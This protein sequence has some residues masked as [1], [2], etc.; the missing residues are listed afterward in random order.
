MNISFEGEKGKDLTERVISNLKEEGVKEHNSIALAQNDTEDDGGDI[1][2]VECETIAQVVC[3]ELPTEVSEIKLKLNQHIVETKAE[4]QKIKENFA[5][6]LD[7]LKELSLN[8]GTKVTEYCLTSLEHENATL[9]HENTQLRRENDSLKERDATHNTWHTPGHRARTNVHNISANYACQNKTARSAA[10]MNAQEPDIIT[11]NRF[12]LLS[13]EHD[14]DKESESNDEIDPSSKNNKSVKLVFIAGD[15]ILQHVHGWDLSNDKQRV[16]VKSFSGSKADDMQDYIKPL[17]RKKPD[18]II[19]HVGTN[20]IKDNAKT[21]EVVAA[22][23]LNLG[24]QIKDSLPYHALTKFHSTASDSTNEWF[25]NMDRG[26][27]N[28]AVFLD[29]QKAFDTINHDILLTKLD[30]YGLQKPSLNLLVSYLANRTQMC[31]VNGALSGT[32]LV[33]CGIPQGSTLGPLLFLI[34]INDLPN[35]LEYSSTRMFADD[36]ILTVSG[37]SM[38]DVEVAINHDLT[39][40]KQWLSA[41]RLSLNL[42]KTEYLLIGSR[43]N[44]NNL[45]AAPNVFV[46]DTPIKKLGMSNISGNITTVPPTGLE[47]PVKANPYALFQGIIITVLAFLRKRTSFKKDVWGGRPGLVVPIDFLGIDNDR[48][49]IMCV[50]GAATGSITNLIIVRDVGQN[51]WGAA[52][53]SIG[54]ALEV[55]FLY[56]P[57]FGCLASYHRIIGALMGLPYVVVY[58]SISMTADLQK[59]NGITTWAQYVFEILPK[60]PTIL[61][62]LFIMGKFI[63]VLYKEIKEYG[64]FGMQLFSPHN[65][66]E[67][68]HEHVKL[69]R[70]WLHDHVNDLIK[71]KKLI[72]SLYSG[73]YEVVTVNQTDQGPWA[74]WV[75]PDSGQAVLPTTHDNEE[76]Y[77]LGM[78]VTFA[79]TRPLEQDDQKLPP[80]PILFLLTTDG[81]LCPFYIVYKN[82]KLATRI[83]HPPQP[84]AVDGERLASSSGV[85]KPAG[86][87]ATQAAPVTM[88]PTKAITPSVTQATNPPAT[89]STSFTAS[90]PPVLPDNTKAPQFGFSPLTGAQ[91]NTTPLT[92]GPSKATQATK[93][94]TT[95]T[96]AVTSKPSVLPDNTRAPQFG[97]TP[98]T[99]TPPSTTLP[100]FG[101]TKIFGSNLAGMPTNPGNVSFSPV[102]LPPSA[103]PGQTGLFQ[104]RPPQ[105]PPLTQSGFGSTLSK[106]GP[107]SFVPPTASTPSSA[108]SSTSGLRTTKPTEPNVPP[109]TDPTHKSTIPSTT[110]APD[111]RGTT[112]VKTP[113]V[114]NAKPPPTMQPT[115]N[116][117]TPV[118]VKKDGV[119]PGS[120]EESKGKPL[121]KASPSKQEQLE[122]A[123]HRN[124]RN[125]ASL[126]KMR[127]IYSLHYTYGDL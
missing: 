74:K 46:G 54:T 5:E 40:V 109:K 117:G 49:A 116:L 71:S 45:L 108:Q 76:T 36:T 119:V 111:V 15:S 59:C 99:G 42:V 88:P 122:A 106:S 4:L 50:F 102:S 93:L 65:L 84:L 60:I 92:F 22:G 43:Y 41:N 63:L 57:Y 16:S 120:K 103:K 56:Y 55:A 121:A 75:L 78:A 81:V 90:K 64:I 107:L 87:L 32:K 70:P 2:T 82:S 80:A 53:L 6:Q 27:F 67:H 98:F 44:I 14:S 114:T 72:L 39:N 11:P 52:F 35:S 25:I 91:P 19:L 17:L 3:N 73:A 125:E 47:L 79:V 69:I 97:S 48:L 20:N 86:S 29:L 77:P 12:G 10:D 83:C 28:I 26:L 8:G 9:R 95:S 104:F 124:I 68:V 62:Q 34:Y 110:K 113:P 96:S 127:Y 66:D 21:A 38:Q 30:L 33:T 105:N 115:P 101:S 37:K 89:T 100:S 7:Q 1:T 118:G 51:V 31:S 123:M 61:C 23:I 85:P 126:R 112:P 24:T 58:F 94:T 18:E 13:T